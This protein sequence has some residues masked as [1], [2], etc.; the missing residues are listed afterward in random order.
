VDTT[1][2]DAEIYASV[3]Y[4]RIRKVLAALTLTPNDVGVGCGRGRVVCC[5]A[6]YNCAQVLGV[7]LCAD[8]RSNAAHMRGRKSSISIHEGAAQEFDY[9]GATTLY[10]FNPFGAATLDKV[11]CKLRNDLA[12]APVRLAFVNIASFTS[13]VFS[14]HDWL[15][16][17][18]IWPSQ[19]EGVHPAA[20]YARVQRPAAVDTP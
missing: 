7:E 10:F 11:L 14:R 18:D 9:H 15:Q 13:E 19:G 20:F 17:Q 6:R 1:F 3:D 16:L 5:A 12:G 8:A 2:P 4:A